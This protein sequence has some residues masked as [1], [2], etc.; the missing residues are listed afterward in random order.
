MSEN[1]R[2]LCLATNND[3]KV[4]ELQ[5][6]L[7][8]RFEIRTMKQIGCED[9]IE[10]TGTTFEENSKIKAAWIYEKFGFDTIADDSGLEVRALNNEPGV[11][12]ARYAGEH[13]NHQKN[14]EKL[15]RV[16][17]DRTDRTARFRAV[18]TL[19]SGGDVHVFEGVVNGQITFQ[20]SGAKGFGYD[21]VFIPDG[22]K[23]TFAEMSSDEKNRISHRGKAVEK[24][25]E[26]L[27]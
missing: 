24:L 1:K 18:I 20:P 9:E 22:Y 12:S 16:L 15:L 8:D 17:G 3:H 2:I 26:Y 23:Q 27:K 5:Q 19:I 25:L 6:M 10:E 13:G 21:P 11:Y 14:I 7:G 4:E